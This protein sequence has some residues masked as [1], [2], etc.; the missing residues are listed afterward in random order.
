MRF[1]MSKRLRVLFILGLF[2]LGSTIIGFFSLPW[3]LLSSF[4]TEAAQLPTA[5]VIIH[6]PSTPRSQS[7]EWA[8]ELYQKGKAKKIVCASIPISWD[9]YAADFSRQ[10]LIALG[11]PAEDV[12]TLHLD[13]EACA[14]PNI[15]RV[16]AYV[17]S[18]GWQRVLLVTGPITE[19]Y[20]LQK[21]FQQEGLQLSLTY[22]QKDRDELSADWW[23]THWK[24]QVMTEAVIGGLLD[25]AYAECR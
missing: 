20:R 11:A 10:H 13:Q 18:Q 12:L 3:L 21:Y 4:P 2:F 19:G 7:D 1:Q 6:W 15:R 23:K 24:M 8:L 16:A 22:A 5:D 14:T 25:S 9:I 17:K